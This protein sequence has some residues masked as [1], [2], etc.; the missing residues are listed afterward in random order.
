MELIPSRRRNFQAIS[1]SHGG[2]SWWGTSFSFRRRGSQIP[3]SKL[4][5]GSLCIHRTHIVCS[6]HRSGFNENLTVLVVI[7]NGCSLGDHSVVL[8]VFQVSEV[9]RVS[10][11]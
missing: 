3:P 2:C 9:D 6:L 4:A 11:H 5:S 1:S 10:A 7:L 8:I